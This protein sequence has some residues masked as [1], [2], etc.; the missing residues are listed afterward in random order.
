[1]YKEKCIY[2]SFV[3][4]GEHHSIIV[5]LP[6]S[7]MEWR[8]LIQLSGYQRLSILTVVFIQ[9]NHSMLLFSSERSQP[10]REII[11]QKCNGKCKPLE[12]LLGSHC[13]AVAIRG[14]FCGVFLYSM[15]F[16]KNQTFVDLLF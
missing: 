13:I 11:F 3:K 16:L 12:N 5:S 1:M 4:Y 2:C 6:L 9:P 14:V 8:D 10:L 7:L 15:F